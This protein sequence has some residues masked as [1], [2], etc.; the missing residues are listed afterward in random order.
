MLRINRRHYGNEYECTIDVDGEEVELTMCFDVSSPEPDVG[1]FGFGVDDYEFTMRDGSPLPD[2][3][4]AAIE[5]A[6]E[7]WANEQCEK[8]IV[9]YEPYEPDYEPD[10]YDD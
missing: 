8:A 5:A 9:D 4:N 10:D 1:L 3:I 6:G 7:E 2:R